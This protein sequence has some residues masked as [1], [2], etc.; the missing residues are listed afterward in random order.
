MSTVYFE[1]KTR[2]VSSDLHY[3]P[4]TLGRQFGTKAKSL[5]LSF[6]LHGNTGKK[7]NAS[8]QPLDCQEQVKGVNYQNGTFNTKYIK[9]MISA[10]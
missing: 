2:C 4:S 3:R 6:T 9:T 5:Y 7:T 10:A 8:Q 1:N